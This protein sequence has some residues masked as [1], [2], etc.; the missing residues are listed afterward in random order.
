MSGAALAMQA[1]ETEHVAVVAEDRV[2]RDRLAW[3]FFPFF[4]G[5]TR[6]DEVGSRRGP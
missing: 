5:E 4:F 1:T 6:R 2:Q 3:S